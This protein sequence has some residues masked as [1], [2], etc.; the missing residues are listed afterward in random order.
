MGRQLS[1]PGLW[2]ARHA[3]ASGCHQ[4]RGRF[5][6]GVSHGIACAGRYSSETEELVRAL[7]PDQMLLLEREPWNPHDAAAVRVAD[8]RGRTLGYVPR[9]DGQNSRYGRTEHGFAITAST[10]PLGLTW[11][12]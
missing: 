5:Y 6:H 12:A 1:Q 4:A 2:G 8:L 11:P 7:Q 9:K 10:G 3:P